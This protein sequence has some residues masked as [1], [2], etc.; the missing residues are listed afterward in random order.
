M[1][2]SY[3]F[4]YGC[5]APANFPAPAGKA[6]YSAKC[7]SCHRLLP[8]QDYTG[9][10]WKDYVIKYGE[11]M[12]ELQRQELLNYLQKNASPDM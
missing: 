10:L 11:Q 2:Q 9:D 1:L 7:A 4:I 3:L 8:P 12:T 6:L 5:S